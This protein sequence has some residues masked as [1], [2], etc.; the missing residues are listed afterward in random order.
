QLDQAIAAYEK[1]RNIGN[2]DRLVMMLAHAY[3]LKGD[4]EKALQ[5]LNQA[6]ELEAQ[7][8]VWAYGV[9]LVYL[10][11]GDKNEAINWLEQAYKNKEAARIAQIKVDPLVDPLRGDPRFEVL[12][13]RVL[14]PR[15]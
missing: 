13:N 12:V 6:K 7:S 4:R 1:G 15:P 5:L 14:P 8:G 11:L 10:G 9:A 2:D 3:A